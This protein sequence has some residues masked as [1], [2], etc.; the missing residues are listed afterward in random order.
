MAG[1]GSRPPGI[2][3]D[4]ALSLVAGHAVLV[5]VREQDEWDAGHAPKAQH[6]PLASV[7]T[8]LAALPRDVPV[9]VICRSGRRSQ[10]AVTSMREAGIDAYNVDGGM[11]GWHLS[12]GDV[13]TA[14][15][16]AGTVI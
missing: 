8:T 15:G 1:S 5:D 6:I 2:D 12:G 4:E 13:I 14:D 16:D 10:S 7:T 11:Q 3:A 9:L